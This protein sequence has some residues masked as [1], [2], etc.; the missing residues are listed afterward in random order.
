MPMH[1]HLIDAIVC[2]D[3]NQMR[4]IRLLARSECEHAA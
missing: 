4:L 2:G 1:Q 3:L